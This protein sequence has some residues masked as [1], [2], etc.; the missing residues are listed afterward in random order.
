MGTK[1]AKLALENDPQFV[2]S[3]KAIQNRQT[4]DSRA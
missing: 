4:G 1:Q 2:R 3:Y